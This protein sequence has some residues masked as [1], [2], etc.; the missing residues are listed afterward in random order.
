MSPENFTTLDLDFGINVN[1]S[2][3]MKRGESSKKFY[4]VADGIKKGRVKYH[5]Y[6]QNIPTK[7]W[8]D[9][10]SLAKGENFQVML[11]P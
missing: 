4:V 8:F 6:D 3:N 5:Y 2:S 9:I 10:P 7:D 1:A 11:K